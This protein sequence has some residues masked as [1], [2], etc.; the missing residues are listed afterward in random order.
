MQERDPL[1]QLKKYVLDT[2]ILTEQQVKPGAVFMQLS[3]SCR[4]ISCGLEFLTFC[5][6]MVRGQHGFLF[7]SALQ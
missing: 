7:A 2:G 6:H 1:P 4:D 5:P 3:R